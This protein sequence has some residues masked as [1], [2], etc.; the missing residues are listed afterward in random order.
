MTATICPTPSSGPY[1]TWALMMEPIFVNTVLT[2]L[3]SAGIQPTAA[4]ATSPAA[5]AYSTRSWPRVSFQTRSFS[6][7]ALSLFH[8]LALLLDDTRVDD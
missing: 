6:T 2:V 3:L 8:V 4:T 1:V 5:S 7:N